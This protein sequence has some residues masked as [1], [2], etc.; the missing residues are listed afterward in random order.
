MTKT[1]PEQ[2][3]FLHTADMSELQKFHRIAEL[4][5]ALVNAREQN[6]QLS[7]ENARLKLLTRETSPRAEQGAGQ[8]TIALPVPAA[9][10]PAPPREAQ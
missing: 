4:T 5:R 7:R 1:K 2:V 6:N 9:G 3:A 10:S 8:P